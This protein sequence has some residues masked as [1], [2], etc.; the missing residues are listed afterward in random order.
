MASMA[1]NEAQIKTVL[2]EHIGELAGFVGASLRDDASADEVERGLWER[3]LKLGHTAMKQFF[4]C[5]GTGD[6]GETLSTPDDRQLKRFKQP[7]ARTYQTVFGEFDL[8]R[9]VYGS[10]DGQKIERVPL[11]ERLQLP[12]RKFSYLLQ[13][14]NQLMTTEMPFSKVNRFLGRILT[15]PQSVNSLEQSHRHL[16]TAVEPFWEQVAI[17][18]VEE[19]G[20]LLVTTAD[21]KGVIMRAEEQDAAAVAAAH[22]QG[23]PG[24]RKMALVGSVYTVDTY[25]R[26]PEQVLAALF[27][28]PVDDEAANDSQRPIPKHKRV[29]GALLRDE[30]DTTAPQSDELFG[31]IAREARERGLPAKK[32]LVLIM[33]GQEALWDSGLK[34]LAQD[35]FTVTEILDLIHV[36]QYAWK[37][38]HVFYAKGS[39]EAEDYARQ[40]IR[41]LLN[42]GV[43][44]V[45]DLLHEKSQQVP[46]SSKAVETLETVCTYFTNQAHRMRYRDYLEKGY[47]V[48]SGV[49]EGACRHVV[50][51]R[52]EQ[53]GM[54]W[55]MKGAHAMLGLRSI[56]LSGLWD[57]FMKRWQNDEA[58]RLYP[59]REEAEN[60]ELYA[61]AKTA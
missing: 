10:R 34:H 54:R 22:K 43:H 8:P 3:M 36:T 55:T 41:R 16:S 32:P 46:L 49:I 44:E 37:A 1:E 19:E 23:R 60:D 56:Q 20:E 14:W 6:V 11:D 24:N 35:E 38:S 47:P 7:H 53:S 45:I 57:D 5:C 52:M 33:D 26:T 25:T 40:H 2:Y 58:R 15:F 17:P 21:G 29:R 9:A 48:A 42:N 59:Q 51:D 13:D 30:Q 4:I 28:E 18:P 50:K 39:D 31:W 27:R 61:V 12:E